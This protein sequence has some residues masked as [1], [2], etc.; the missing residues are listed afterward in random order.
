M[1]ND[2]KTLKTLEKHN[3]FNIVMKNG[4]LFFMWHGTAVPHKDRLPCSMTLKT[5]KNRL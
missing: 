4:E 3:D 2:P 1:F 5:L